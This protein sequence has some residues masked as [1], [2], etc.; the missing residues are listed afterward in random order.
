MIGEE[1]VFIDD[2][3]LQDIGIIVKLDS[4]EP[5]LPSTRDQ[6]VTIPGSHGAYDY[7][8]WLQPRTFE[9]ACMFKRKNYTDL[10]QKIRKFINLLLDYRGRPKDLK[11]RFGDEP[12]KYYTVRYSGAISLDR[13]VGMPSFILPLTAYNPHA[14]TITSNDEVTWGSKEI[15]FLNTAYTFGHTGGGKAKSITSPQNYP[16]YVSGLAIKP[17][18]TITGTGTNVT[19]STNSKACSLGTFTNTNWIIDLEEYTVIRNGVNGLSDF[20]GDF[21]E[22]M[23]GQNQISIG[24]SNLNFTIQ[25]KFEDKFM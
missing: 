10:K 19:L 14:Y 12:Q 4:Q 24:G 21:L 2:I 16:V 11:L 23:P 17:I 3:K 1:D 18:I 25:V 7:G 15:T 8:A 20:N 5:L 6:F 9:L 22:F 13:L